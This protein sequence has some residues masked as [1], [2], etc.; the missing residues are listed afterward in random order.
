MCDLF[1]ISVK[2]SFS[3]PGYSYANT[4]VIQSTFHQLSVL[5]E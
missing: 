2:A 1:A 3:T 4:G 5:S